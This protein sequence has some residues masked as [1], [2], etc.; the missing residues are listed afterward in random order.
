MTR[1]KWII[2]ALTLVAILLAWLW[3][4]RDTWQIVR[5]ETWQALQ[6]ELSTARELNRVAGDK[7]ASA[8]I[9]LQQALARIDGLEGEVKRRATIARGRVRDLDAS[10]VARELDRFSV[11][12][13][14]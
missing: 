13:T 5:S 2:I 14:P 4:N 10:G 7:L 6:K 1:R 11:G 12:G 3:N 9:K 8:D